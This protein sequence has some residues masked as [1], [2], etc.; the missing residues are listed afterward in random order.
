MKSNVA[1]TYQIDDIDLAVSELL[2]GIH[3][4]FALLSNTVGI[5]FCYSDMEGGLLAQR[6][7]EKA[8]F[9]ILGCTGIANMEQREGFHNLAATLLVLTA[10]D[11]QFALAA[12]GAIAS[13]EAVQPQLRKAYQTACDALPGEPKLVFCIPPYLLEVM[14]DAYTNAFNDIA[15]GVPVVGGLPSYNASGDENLVFFRGEAWTDRLVMLAI[16]GNVHPVFSVQNVGSLDVSRKR[17]VT[18]A[19]DNVIYEVGNQRFTD[20]L[21]EVGL[22]VEELS[23]GNATITFVSNP[24]LLE[25][26]SS[27]TGQEFSFART[28]HEINPDE[29]SGT[30]IGEIPVGATLSICSLERGEIEQKAKEGMLTIRK[31]IEAVSAS[32]YQFS[33][34]LAISCIGRHL[35]LLP[36]NSVEVERLLSVFPEGLTMAGFYSYG[37]IGPQGTA[38]PRNFA[39]NESLVLCAF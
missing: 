19:V 24:L 1:V 32:G 37:E 11:C 22:P 5:L 25:N 30:A 7:Q 26:Q 6:L 39:H 16:S 9:D 35:L 36:E 28:L 20:Y 33:T 29:G 10:E 14:L 4:D 15:P 34:L 13:A 2:E 27:E 12:T 17:K 18:K 38:Q 8:G 31:E 23:Q 21:E 3:K